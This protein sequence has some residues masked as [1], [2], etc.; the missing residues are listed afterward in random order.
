MIHSLA[1][2]L[3]LAAMVLMFGAVG[4]EAA[5]LRQ[6]ARA[7]R[8]DDAKLAL[9]AGAFTRV[10]GPVALLTVVVTGVYLAAQI[11]EAA[12]SWVAPSAIGLV[13]VFLLGAAVTGRKMFG[14]TRAVEAGGEL[15]PA[16][17]ARFGDRALR[18]SFAAR[19]ILLFA[20]L[21]LMVVKP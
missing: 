13:V 3:H 17:S 8:V 15:T 7:R 4:V 18:V 9:D 11:G 12:T 5:L 19:G 1:L 20:I 21:A 14:I 2:F 10:L 6:L 16:L